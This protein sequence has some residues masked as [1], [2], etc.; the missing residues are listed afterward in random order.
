[1]EAADKFKEAIADFDRMNSKRWLLQRRFQIQK[2]HELMS[3][4]TIRVSFKKTV[5]GGDGFY[6]LYPSS[7]GFV[8]MSAVGFNKEK[9]KAI[10]YF[11]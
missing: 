10:V 6:K 1:V 11:G 3:S 8:I 7:G 5:M 9:S 4:D 2:P